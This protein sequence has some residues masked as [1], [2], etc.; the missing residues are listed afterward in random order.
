MIDGRGYGFGLAR[1][2]RGAE[3]GAMEVQGSGCRRG[4]AGEL[5]EEGLRVGAGGGEHGTS[6]AGG[7]AGT[8]GGFVGRGEAGAQLTVKVIG[9]GGGGGTRQHGR[10]QGPGS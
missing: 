4:R 3:G 8:K 6:T 7:E 5:L 2:G 9:G 10:A 1:H